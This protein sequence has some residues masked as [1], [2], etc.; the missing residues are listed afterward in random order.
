LGLKRALAFAIVGIPSMACSTAAVT[1]P[2]QT[3]SVRTLTQNPGAL[4]TV[5][6]SLTIAQGVNVTSI[7]W[8]ISGPD[9]YSGTA[10]FGDAQSAEFVIGGIAAGTGYTVTLSGTDS[11]NDP[12]SGMSGTFSVAAGATTY[13]LE[14]VTCL[15]PT[16]ATISPDVTTGSVA[17]EAGVSVV[18][19]PPLQFPG[20][21]S[22]TISPAEVA[23]G[24]PS[25][26]GIATIGSLTSINWSVSPSSGAT[27]ANPTSAKPHVHVQ[28]AGPIYRECVDCPLHRPSVHHVYGSHQL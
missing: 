9:S 10:N 7:N 21:N 4:G 24:Q 8:S 23:V 2:T 19:D 22:F 16:D 25:A 26:L 11:N 18:P 6:L 27:I 20:I 13:V 14:S 5:G 12:C 15:E 28:P 1:P 17:V 3:D